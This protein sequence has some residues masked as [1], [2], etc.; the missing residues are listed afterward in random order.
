VVVP[1]VSAVGVVVELGEEEL[2]GCALAVEGDDDELEPFEPEPLDCD[3]EPLDCEPGP[4]DCE[5]EPLDGEPEPLEWEPEPFEQS[6]STYCWSPADGSGQL[7]DDAVGARRA[8]T[9]RTAKHA[10][11]RQ[12]RILRVLQP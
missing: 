8:S 5:P 4:L 11:K 10:G 12:M 2:T 3:P 6:G 9:T 7:A 1:A